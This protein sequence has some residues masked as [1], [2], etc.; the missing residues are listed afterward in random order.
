[1]NKPESMS[2]KEWIIKNISRK[3]MI[4]EKTINVV[5]THQFDSANEALKNKNSVELYEF[6]K[7]LFKE[8]RAK[9]F[10]KK[11][12]SKKEVFTN[13]MNDEN[14]SETKRRSASIKLEEALRHI[15]DIELKLK[16]VKDEN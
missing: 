3:L 10:L 9:Y 2:I 12:Y 8:K 4:P 11:V 6:G 14:V 1:M 7:F 16:I 15:K 5:I 13:I